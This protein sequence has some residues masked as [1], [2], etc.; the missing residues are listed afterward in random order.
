LEE[1]R[2]TFDDI[3]HEAK[4]KLPNVEYKSANTPKITR[5]GNIGDGDAPSADEPLSPRDKFRIK[6]FIPIMNALE[7]NLKEKLNHI[8]KFC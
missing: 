8:L 5:K 2:K 3:E 4:E 1:T 7:T 6:S